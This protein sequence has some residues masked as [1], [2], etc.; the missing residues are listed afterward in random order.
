VKLG[1]GVPQKKETRFRVWVCW[2]ASGS[3]QAVAA[4]TR[5]QATRSRQAGRQ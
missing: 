3:E 4:A 1:F 5:R 2:S